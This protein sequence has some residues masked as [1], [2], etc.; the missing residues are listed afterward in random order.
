MFETIQKLTDESQ[1]TSKETLDASLRAFAE[2]NKGFQA[3]TAEVT[4]YSKKVF[5]DGTR[6]FEQ[7]IGAKSVEQAVEVQ[8]QY[9]K[10]AFDSW[11]AQVAKL[12]EMY[13]ALAQDAYRPV[14]QTALKNARK[15]APVAAE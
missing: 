5:E 13:V 11:T 2:L 9:A 10:K 15:A 8:S 4:N 6:A 1:R 12:Q 3:I 14:E 7:L